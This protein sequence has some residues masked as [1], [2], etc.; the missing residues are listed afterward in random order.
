MKKQKRISDTEF[1]KATGVTKSLFKST[2]SQ[3]GPHHCFTSIASKRSIKTHKTLKI[4][5][6][7]GFG[8]TEKGV[9]SL[10]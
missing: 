8:G 5:H 2:T 9:A 4:E 1:L 10:L 6:V 7:I 3:H